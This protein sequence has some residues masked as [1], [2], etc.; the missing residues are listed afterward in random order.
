M[1]LQQMNASILLL[2]A[3]IIGSTTAQFYGVDPYRQYGGGYR[4]YRP[5]RK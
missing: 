1:T 2:V 5:Y 3:V 4:P